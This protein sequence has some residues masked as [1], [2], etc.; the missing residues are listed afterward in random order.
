M[1]DVFPVRWGEEAL[2]LFRR[3]ARA[4]VKRRLAE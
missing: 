4:H 1:G 3:N 2:R